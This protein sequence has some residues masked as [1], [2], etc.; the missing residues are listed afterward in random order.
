[1]LL[2]YFIAV[3]NNTILHGT[4]TGSLVMW[5][6]GRYAST[7]PSLRP[8]VESA[9]GLWGS[10]RASGDIIS[11]GI[12]CYALRKPLPAP[13]EEPVLLPAEVYRELSPAVNL[14]LRTFNNRLLELLKP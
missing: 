10:I 6:F 11:I 1:M 2:I 14:R 13:A 7:W 4:L 5:L 8:Q 3:M 9:F 12:W